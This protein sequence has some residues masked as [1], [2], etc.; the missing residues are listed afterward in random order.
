MQALLAAIDEHLLAELTELEHS[1]IQNAVHLD[2]VV[3]SCDP[4]DDTKLYRVTVGK[5]IKMSCADL[6]THA[7]WARNVLAHVSRGPI[8][9][10]MYW[11]MALSDENSN[12]KV[13]DLMFFKADAIHSEFSALL[14][15]PGRWEDLWHIVQVG[16]LDE[17]EWAERT[18]CITL[19][20]AAGLHD[21][22]NF[23]EWPYKLFYLIM[24]P[25]H[26]VCDVRKAIGLELLTADAASLKC[27]FTMKFKMLFET[28]LS[29]AAESGQLHDNVWQLLRDIAKQWRLDTQSI[30]GVNGLLKHMLKQAPNMHIKLAS[31]RVTI[32]KNLSA[33]LHNKPLRDA[34]VQIAVQNHAATVEWHRARTLFKK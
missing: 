19:E 23:S 32:K 29:L 31:S 20:M 26:D 17:R 10:L 25:G 8:M 22:C 6:R 21:R 28:S 11:M 30:E 14:S 5:W 1:E 3:G 24:S 34:A 2:G 13:L 9:H 18:I 12:P 7:F 33:V 27:K 16:C 15:E 4:S